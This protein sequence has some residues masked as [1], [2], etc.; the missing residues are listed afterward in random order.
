[1]EGLS[2]INALRPDISALPAT[3][4][5]G[6]PVGPLD[7]HKVFKNSLAEVNGMDTQAKGMVE[8][9]ATGES[10]D[11]SG[12]ML[13]VRKANLAFLSILQVRNKLVEAYQEVMRMR[14]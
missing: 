11:V 1:M 5:P 9:L 4:L 12:T 14:M 13:A 3:E 8:A 6:N 2:S 7:F 10:N